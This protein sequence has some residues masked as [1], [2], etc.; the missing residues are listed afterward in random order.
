MEFYYANYRSFPFFPFTQLEKEYKETM[1]C[2]VYSLWHQIIRANLLLHYFL[3]FHLNEV[4]FTNF[5]I[6]YGYVTCSKL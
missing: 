4:F 6:L 2:D 5:D 3:R 1:H